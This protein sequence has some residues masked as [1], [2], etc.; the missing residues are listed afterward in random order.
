MFNLQCNSCLTNAILNSLPLDF[1]ATPS[2]ASR[3]S[4]YLSN[5][6]AYEPLEKST[7]ST[8]ALYLLIRSYSNYLS[9]EISQI[10]YG[11][12]ARTITLG[13]TDGLSTTSSGFFS[14]FQPISVPVGSI[15]LGRILN[16]TG[17]I[18]DPYIE[19]FASSIFQVASTFRTAA[20]SSPQLE[21]ELSFPELES[22]ACRAH[23]ASFEI[24]KLDSNGS[25]S[26][27]SDSSETSAASA[28]SIGIPSKSLYLLTLDT[29]FLSILN[30]NSF[31]S[32][33]PSNLEIS[34]LP[35]EFPRTF[36]APLVS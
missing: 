20:S 15:T 9:A 26:Y 13:T 17:S 10:C 30:K 24:Q 22:Y 19:L 1:S 32:S 8:L 7:S 4:S 12:I 11:G 25:S 21:L 3:I 5:D 16:V 2:Q 28:T 6:E 35:I 23:C 34:L 29:I 33:I 36:L 27:A 31:I 18:L 14:I